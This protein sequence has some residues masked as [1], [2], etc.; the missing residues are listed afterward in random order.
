MDAIADAAEID[1]MVNLSGYTREAA[2]YELATRAPKR[3]THPP[4]DL[5]ID[6]THVPWWVRYNVVTAYCPNCGLG[7]LFMVDTRPDERNEP[8]YPDE[9]CQRC[10]GYL[11]FC[12]CPADDE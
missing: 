4:A 2:A 9:C 8:A 6:V 12:D 7:R 11:G 3:C 1:R 10:G 5:G